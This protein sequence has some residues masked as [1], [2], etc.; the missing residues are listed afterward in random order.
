MK[1]TSQRDTTKSVTSGMKRNTKSWKEKNLKKGG[2]VSK[3]INKS[4]QA[5]S[6]IDEERKSRAQSSLDP[7]L[8]QLEFDGDVMYRSDTQL[9]EAGSEYDSVIDTARPVSPVD[10]SFKTLLSLDPNRKVPSRIP[11]LTGNLSKLIPPRAPVYPHPLRYF[12]GELIEKEYQKVEMLQKSTLQAGDN[13]NTCQELSPR[14]SLDAFQQ[15]M[16]ELKRPSSAYSK[17]SFKPHQPE[18]TSTKTKLK[19]DLHVIPQE[20]QEMTRPKVTKKIDTSN[21]NWWIKELDIFRQTRDEL[22]SAWMY[23]SCLVLG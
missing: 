15:T 13:S 14:R 11:R 17:L 4:I 21:A 2:V 9:G 3:R 10:Y 23:L 1:S 16:L 12:A 22:H 19:R 5:L 6:D 7:I 18:R 20:H 8:E